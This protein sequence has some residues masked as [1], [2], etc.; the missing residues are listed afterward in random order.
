MSARQRWLRLKHWITNIPQ[1]TGAS[2]RI[3][4]RS[5][6]WPNQLS[7]AMREFAGEQSFAT[8]YLEP[9]DN[10]DIAVAARSFEVDPNGFLAQVEESRAQSLAR[11][12]LT[13]RMLLKLYQEGGGM[14]STLNELFAEGLEKLASDPE[15]RVAIGTDLALSSPALLAAAEQLA[16]YT[17]LSGRETVNLADESAT[18]HLVWR[19]LSGAVGEVTALDRNTL[20]TV[21]ASGLCDSTSPGSFRF[22][23]RQFA[24]YLAGRRLGSLPTHQSRVFLASPAGW[25]AGVAGPLR[26][27]AA[28]AAMFNGELATWLANQDPE[29]VGLSDVTDGRLR[30]QAMLGLLDRFRCG[31]MTDAQV[32]RGEIELRGFQYND[33]EEDLRPILQE[34]QRGCEDVHEYAIALI[35]SWKLSSMSDDLADLALD[36]AAPL[37]SRITSSYA[38]LECGTDGARARLKSLLV[39]VPEDERSQLKGLA[40][41]C[42]W[43]DGLS[44]PE[45]LSVLT[46]RRQTSFH[47]AYE[48]YLWKLHDE[49]FAAT[50][51]AAIGLRW[52]TACVS[53]LG[54]VDVIHRLGMQIARAALLEL[55]DPEVASEMVT[56]LRHWAKCHQSPLA[57]PS[58]NALES[59]AQGELARKLPLCANREARRQLI[60]Q[61]AAAA[62][63]VEELL[64]LVYLTPGLRDANDFVWLLGR[65]CE[66][67]R[68]MMERQNYL[69]IARL[70]PWEHQ[71]ENV[72]AWLKVCDVDPVNTLLGIRKSVELDS[73]EAKQL[74]EW[75][76]IPNENRRRIEPPQI[77]PPPSERVLHALIHSET[78][79]IRYF[80]NVCRELTLEPTSTK[81]GVERFLTNMPGWHAADV[82]TQTRIVEIGKAYLSSEAIIA[83]SLRDVSSYSYSVDVLGAMWLI[84]ERDPEWLKSRDES[85]WKDWCRYILYQLSPNMV[86]EPIDPK[87]RLLGFLNEAV[88]SAL[89][90]EIVRL[91]SNDVVECADDQVAGL[92]NL[93]IGE[94]DSELDRELRQALQRG[95]IRKGA[96]LFRRFGSASV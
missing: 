73:E 92:L 49:G 17:I 8:A 48:G 68:T 42:N 59:P 57:A 28:F 85:W 20:R 5:A 82:G 93:L 95:E 6:V 53:D 45:L 76:W 61:L 81:Y 70:L 78:D 71:A 39:G 4:C 79:D 18:G 29:V 89:R 87:R 7:E 90:S 83:E 22:G 27:T 75:W 34:R 14:P 74:R 41:R 10:D 21:G 55:D 64:Q 80:R 12:P 96:A 51:H 1:D 47:G 67:H 26:E 63:A 13:L 58:N 2:V 52:A 35:N 65:G 60:D 37:Q 23:H 66:E 56:L 86:G 54:D 94:S 69:Q 43:P 50:G 24:E 62:L 19:D 11:Q 3:T 40:L 84:L 46:A 16:C 72:E 33:A 36:P 31:D 38:L 91:S 9:L 30:R 15:E 44:V 25:R 77:D 88:P 32:H